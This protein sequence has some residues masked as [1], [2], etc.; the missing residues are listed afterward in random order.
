MNNCVVY[1]VDDNFYQNT[2]L[3]ISL[4]TLNIY[5]NEMDVFVLT[6][7]NNTFK[8]KNTIFIDDYLSY[9]DTNSVLI[10]KDLSHIIMLKLFIPLIEQLSIYD[11]VLF[12]DCDIEIT[13]NLNEIF[14]SE[15]YDN[16]ILGEK[17]Y[18]DIPI[19]LDLKLK[20]NGYDLKAFNCHSK[21]INFGA[22]LYNMKSK[23][24]LDKEKYLQNLLPL[25]QIIDKCQFICP[26]QDGCFIFD[27]IKCG[28]FKKK[29]FLELKPSKIK[30]L[31]K[32]RK[33]YNIHYILDTKKIMLEKFNNGEI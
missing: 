3:K 22:L 2:L 16:D 30:D 17:C 12:L 6:T 29:Y 33:L 32:Y 14:D 7:K 18:N 9:I 19:D 15:F 28:L 21:Y 1:I 23:S 31:E 25:L 8:Y 13:K 11:R 26:E 27:Y 20:N 10:R 5:N 4:K 24:F